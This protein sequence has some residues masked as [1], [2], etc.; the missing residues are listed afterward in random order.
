MQLTLTRNTSYSSNYITLKRKFEQDLKNYYSSIEMLRKLIK[1]EDNF[2][3]LAKTLHPI[4]D[5][6]ALQDDLKEDLRFWEWALKNYHFSDE[7][8][9]MIKIRRNK[10][11]KALLEIGRLL[12][13]ISRKWSFKI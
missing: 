7:Q 4:K 11:K 1:D 8:K 3:F 13:E 2:N 6:L 10:T 12:T 5:F 9:R